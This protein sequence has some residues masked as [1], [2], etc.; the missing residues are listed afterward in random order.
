MVC[1]YH[2]DT[3]WLTILEILDDHPREADKRPLYGE[4]P[5]L[6]SLMTDL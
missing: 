3:G 2:V 6:V 5:S 4:G 1:D